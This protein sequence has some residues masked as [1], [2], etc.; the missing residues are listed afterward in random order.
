MNRISQVEDSVEQGAE[1][2]TWS[3]R[4]ESKNGLEKTAK[5]ATS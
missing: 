3:L 1:E 4:E 2:G 5:W